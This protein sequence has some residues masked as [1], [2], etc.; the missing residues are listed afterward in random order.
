[1]ALFGK[2]S[3][4]FLRSKIARR[5]LLLFFLC[6]LL[7]IL[8]FSYLAR[9]QVDSVLKNQ[10]QKELQ[11]TAKNFGLLL[12]ERL[13]FLR[14]EAL[15]NRDRFIEWSDDDQDLDLVL[16]EERL[17][18][19]LMLVDLSVEQL[20]PPVA[21]RFSF[22]VSDF[23]NDSL[24]QASVLI[25][26][27]DQS[28]WLVVVFG[29][30]S[31]NLL[32]LKPVQS[33]LWSGLKDYDLTKQFSVYGHA[34]QLLFRSHLE[35]GDGEE[36]AGHK[37]SWYLVQ[38]SLVNDLKW[39]VEAVLIASDSLLDQV[40]FRQLFSLITLLAILL[41]AFIGVNTIRRNLQPIEALKVGID[42]IN[43]NHYGQVVEID[44]GDEFELLGNTFNRMSRRLEKN[45]GALK[46][47]TTIDEIILNR[48]ALEDIIQ[49]VVTEGRELLGA[50]IIHLLLWEPGQDSCSVFSNAYERANIPINETLL[51][52][53]HCPNQLSRVNDMFFPVEVT[54]LLSPDCIVYSVLLPCE[55]NHKAG[56]IAEFSDEPEPGFN[57]VASSFVNH[58]AV[59]LNNAD[60]QQRL[61]RQANYDA[62]TSLPNR[63]RFASQLSSA[64]EQTQL[65]NTKLALYVIDVDRF[66]NVNDVFG[67]VVGDQFLQEVAGRLQAQIGQEHVYRL[68]GDEF[69]VLFP[70]V[71]Q[72]RRRLVRETGAIA[73]S[74]RAA[75][76][77][78]VTVNGKQIETT[79][80]IGIAIY[81]EDSNSEENLLIL[82]DKAMYQAKSLGRNRF[83]YYSE[84]YRDSAV[85]Q[86][87]VVSELRRALSK[88]EFVL[89]YQP[90]VNLKTGLISGCEALIRWQHPDKGLLSPDKFIPQAEA[91]GVIE[92]IGRWVIKTAA[93][94]QR[95]WL[96][97][98]LDV[99]RIAVNIAISQL[100]NKSFFN[101]V[102]TIFKDCVVDAELFEFEI[103]ESAYVKDF[104]DTRFTLEQLSDIGVVLSID[105]Y[106]TGY[107][108]LSR[109]LNFPV[110]C[111][112]IDKSFVDHI[113]TDK[114][115]M[116]IIESTVKL[117]EAMSLLVV[118]EGIEN[119][120][121]LKMLQMSGCH[122]G[123]GYLFSKPVA[124]QEIIG[125]VGRCFF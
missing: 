12:Y 69:V 57:D 125:L 10:Q 100:H 7:P 123:Q 14:Q 77:A 47:L 107:S 110:N 114:V 13:N 39:D 32:F 78:P 102:V 23:E 33:L 104:N 3:Q 112:K 21:E 120:A 74:L 28:V 99:G 90:K 15:N 44:S 45:I 124:A 93:V 118:A 94:Q 109:L 17:F 85:E 96:D 87:Q 89:F 6:A 79:V 117:A 98:G 35:I 19:D 34:K 31:K 122:R 2:F 26:S 30:N 24:H 48:L 82:A 70:C 62:L 84:I 40:E 66:K 111:I 36:L 8:M 121:Q 56:L 38:P 55:S 16:V 60:W 106:G 71:E 103:T 68:G 42:Q 115:S 72:D 51:N 119:S 113:E 83:Q 22:P 27:K 91:Y 75:V 59:A 101:D 41:A 37:A 108:S 88:N 80:S 9:N 58:I 11:R 49:L 116:A 65:S 18:E 67:H 54:N 1:M 86:W 97:E 20:K 50:E 4:S 61:Y 53:L 95:Q 52:T 105:D 73:E 64:I 5:T 25:D 29:P 46:A 76:V 92:D 81:P 63:Y 43:N